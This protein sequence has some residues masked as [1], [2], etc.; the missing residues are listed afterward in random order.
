M[1]AQVVI[2]CTSI[3]MYPDVDATPVPAEC[4]KADMTVFDTVYNP[5]ETLL[6]KQAAQVGARTVSGVEMFI[7]QAMAQYKLFVGT[8]AGDPPEKTMRKT[9]LEHLEKV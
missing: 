4:L 5:A 8:E 2:N 1:D 9:V 6:L 7:R 3:G